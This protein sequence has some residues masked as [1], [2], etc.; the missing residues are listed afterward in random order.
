MSEQNEIPPSQADIEP[1]L[2]QL[3]LPDTETIFKNMQHAIVVALNQLAPYSVYHDGSIR[4]KELYSQVKDCK[5]QVGDHI[6]TG[7][8]RFS[9]F[10][11]ALSGRRSASELFERVDDVGRQ[12]A[13]WKLARSFDECLSIALEQKGMKKI[14]QRV[15]SKPEPPAQPEIAHVKPQNF[16]KWNKPEV[17]DVLNKIKELAIRTSALKEENRRLE[18]RKA[19]LTEEMDIITGS[20]KEQDPTNYRLAQLDEFIR[21]DEYRKSLRAQLEQAQK[22][23]MTV[24]DQSMELQK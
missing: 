6:E 4:M 16:F 8:H 15:R 18:E 20:L 21:A 22:I 10:N 3:P 2:V 5:I 12:G 11:S 9:I 19:T 13:W 1:N 14:Q 24:S 23:L 17:L 7:P